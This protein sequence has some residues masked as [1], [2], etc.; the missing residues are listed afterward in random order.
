MRIKVINWTWEEPDAQQAFAE[1][2]GFPDPQKTR[3][4]LDQI[5]TFLQLR[6][7]LHVLDVGCGTGRH[8]LELARRSYQGD[9][10]TRP[11]S[12]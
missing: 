3:E 8:T 4:E 7:P 11:S 6:P 10:Q 2:V 9:F 1:L 5:E 12:L